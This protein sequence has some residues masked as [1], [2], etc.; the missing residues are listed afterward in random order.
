MFKKMRFV[1]LFEMLL[2]PSFKMMT[3]FAYIAR[4][5]ASTSKFIYKEHFKSLG[6]G[7]LYE[8]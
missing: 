1:I 5:K 6:I 2:N 8:K 7:S 3:S 4:T